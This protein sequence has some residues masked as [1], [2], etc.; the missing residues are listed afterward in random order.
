MQNQGNH[1]TKALSKA[2]TESSGLPAVPDLRSVEAWRDPATPPQAAAAVSVVLAL[3]QPDAAD[4]Q[5][6][7]LVDLVGR[8]GYT[9]AELA[10]AVREL[11]YDPVLDK[12]LQFSGTKVTAADFERWIGEFRSLRKLL[13]VALRQEDVNRLIEKHPNWLSWNDFGICGYTSAETPLYRYCYAGVVSER[14][15][16]P[17]IEEKA[18]VISER[19][20]KTYSISE[21]V[22]SEGKDDLRD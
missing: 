2:S 21:L 16:R 15:P 12:K 7:T 17:Q 1:E 18:E 22:K 3:T 9:Q 6:A 13:A 4:E 5:V 10:Y 20:G 19:E 14:N 11:P 8:R